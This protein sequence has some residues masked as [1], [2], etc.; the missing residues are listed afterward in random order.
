MSLAV[1][2]LA[3]G[4]LIGLYSVHPL[5]GVGALATLVVYVITLRARGEQ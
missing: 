4:A 1:R 5:I 3:V 2:V